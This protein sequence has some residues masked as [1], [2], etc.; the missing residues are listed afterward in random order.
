MTK[1]IKWERLTLKETETLAEL[2]KNGIEVFAA[3]IEIEDNAD[4][5]KRQFASH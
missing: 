2:E 1:E 3:P 4:S 5:R